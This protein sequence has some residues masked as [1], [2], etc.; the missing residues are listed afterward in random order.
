MVTTARVTHATPAAAYAHGPERNWESDKNRT[1]EDQD[2]CWD[3][4]KQLV[5]NDD[6]KILRAVTTVTIAPMSRNTS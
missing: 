3:I 4:A 6:N 1:D 5:L 2:I